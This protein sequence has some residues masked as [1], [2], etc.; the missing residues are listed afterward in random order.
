[1]KKST[2]NAKCN[3]SLHDLCKVSSS[4]GNSDHVPASCSTVTCYQERSTEAVTRSTVTRSTAARSTPATAV[5][6]STED[7]PRTAAENVTCHPTE[8][9]TRTWTEIGRAHV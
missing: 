9:V 6:C 7:A 3:V 4:L 5:Q 2:C 1:M 8:A